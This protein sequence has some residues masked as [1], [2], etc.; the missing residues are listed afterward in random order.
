[1]SALEVLPKE[2]LQLVALDASPKEPSRAPAFGIL[3]LGNVFSAVRS[4]GFAFFASRP[5]LLAL[6]ASSVKSPMEAA[7][8]FAGMA[9]SA[10]QREQPKYFLLCRSSLP[11]YRQ[12][13]RVQFEILSLHGAWT[14]V[15][16]SWTEPHFPSAFLAVM[17]LLKIVSEAAVS[18]AQPDSLLQNSPSSMFPISC[19][20][21]LPAAASLSVYL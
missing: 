11:M 8:S 5:T 12:N 10:E 7:S 17:T 21:S 15:V 16:L 20:Q 6:A 9:S 19:R 14:F 1:M 3:P 2:A 13:G 18:F 4:M